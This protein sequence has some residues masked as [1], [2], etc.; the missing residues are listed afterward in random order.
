MK[1]NSMTIDFQDNRPKGFSNTEGKFLI[2]LIDEIE[3]LIAD[4]QS[5]YGYDTLKFDKKRRRVLSTLII[6]FAEDLHNSIGLWNSVEYYNKQLFNT[7]LPLFVSS[8][9]EIEGVF[10][11][12]R[13]KYF[14]H[15][16]VCEFEP[17]R[18]I[19]PYHKDLD[20]LAK[21]VS[22][23]LSDKF[24]RVPHTSA[25]REFLSQPN[26]LGWDVKRKLLWTGTKSYLFRIGFHRY[27]TK[28]N[29]GKMDIASMD[30]FICHENTLW[31]GLGVID[32]LAKT[33]DLPAKMAAD[34]RSWHER[35]ESYYRVISS[36]D[37][38]LP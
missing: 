2:P 5:L 12:S 6:E 31:S 11:V 29:K 14:I 26:D 22:A 34:V 9:N 21:T 36:T 3:K 32:I 27:I 8:E 30:D 38:T 24:Q 15:T 13:M 19:A 18:V 16:L 33:L 25:I 7:P 23:S 20:L 37:S 35:Y 17:D 10:D 28:N 1:T 4:T